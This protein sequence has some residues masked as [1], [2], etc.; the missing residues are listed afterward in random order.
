LGSEALMIVSV[1]DYLVSV[2]VD[3]KDVLP[4]NEQ[5]WLEL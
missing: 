2:T 1:G 5:V 4:N 3:I